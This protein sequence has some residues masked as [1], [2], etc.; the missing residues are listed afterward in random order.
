MLLGTLGARLLGNIM[1]GKGATSNKIRSKGD[2][3]ESRMK[4]Y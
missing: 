2:S 4:K 1:A 3:N